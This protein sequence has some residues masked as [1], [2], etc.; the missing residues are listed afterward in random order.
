MPGSNQHPHLKPVN[1]LSGSAVKMLSLVTSLSESWK[2]LSVFI[3]WEL[4]ASWFRKLKKM[5]RKAFFF[6]SLLVCVHYE[7]SCSNVTEIFLLIPDSLKKYC[8]S[9]GALHCGCLWSVICGYWIHS[10]SIALSSKESICEDMKHAC[11]VHASSAHPHKA[12]LPS[13]WLRK[14]L[15]NFLLIIF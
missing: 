3:H 11:N 15:P 12:P 13:L 8:T 14:L 4:H 1:R 7:K 10:L 5:Y 6:P 9:C 2:A